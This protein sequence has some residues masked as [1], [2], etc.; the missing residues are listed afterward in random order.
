MTQQPKWSCKLQH[1]SLALTGLNERSGQI[2]WLVMSRSST[3]TI[4]PSGIPQIV[5]VTR[6]WSFLFYMTWLM[7]N[8]DLYGIKL[9][10]LKELKQFSPAKSSANGDVMLLN[11]GS[12]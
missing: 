12:G 4:V 5:L 7:F 3:F 11:C 1:F 9:N 6:L 8:T 10:A 2:N